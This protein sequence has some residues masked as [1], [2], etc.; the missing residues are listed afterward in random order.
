V[1]ALCKLVDKM[2]ALDIEDPPSAERSSL[3]LDDTS[4]PETPPSARIC[5]REFALGAVVSVTATI[6]SGTVIYGTRGS[7]GLF[8]FAAA[9]LM[10]VSLSMD[11]MFAFFLIFRYY[12]TPL[13]CQAV[14]LF[15][16]IA[17]AV[18]LRAFILLLG[19]A[20]VQAAKPLMLGFAVLLL[21]SAYGMWHSIGDDDDEEDLSNNRVVRFVRWLR[22]PVTSDY[23]GTRFIVF[24][25]GTVKVTPLVL[26]LATVELSDIVFAADSVPAV[27]GLSSD[28]LCVY[29]AVMCAIL[30]LRTIYSLTVI[31]IKAFRYLPHAVSLL[32]AFIGVKIALDVL[33][34]L[35]IPTHVSLLV[36]VA[37]LGAGMVVSACPACHMG[38]TQTPARRV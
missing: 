8:G 24:E 37:T 7:E 21:Y 30:G 9:Y 35:T 3:L 25:G 29:V 16:G 19:T 1:A 23:V 2:V 34:G 5:N 15:W 31:L 28:M 20:M 13:D 4:A 36:I 27:L 22:L 38:G 10:E 17:G 33:L 26:V 32:L 6:A 18:M 11:N 14:C 12:K